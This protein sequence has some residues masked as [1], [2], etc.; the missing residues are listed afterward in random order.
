MENIKVIQSID[1]V[2]RIVAASEH[3]VQLIFKH[4]TSCSISG[5]VKNRVYK[6][7]QSRDWEF[8]FHYLDLL[9]Y[10]P[11]SNFIA[12]NLAVKHESPQLIALDKGKVI[13]HTSHLDISLESVASIAG[14]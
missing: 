13:Y 6:Q 11:V 5:F 14:F 2:N 7:L 9:Q 1:D 12:E 3:K 10:R 4:S 8:D